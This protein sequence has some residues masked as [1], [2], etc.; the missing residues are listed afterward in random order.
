MIVLRRYMNNNLRNFNYLIGCEESRQAIAVDPLGADEMLALAEEQ[1]YEIKLI[2]NTHEHHDHIDG[3]PRVQEVTGADIWAHKNAAERIPNVARGLVAGDVVELGTIR[4]TV[5]YTP[6]HTMAHLCLLSEDG[7][8]DGQPVLFSGDTLFNACAGN[9]RNGG[10][11]D[12]LYDTFVA[13]FQPLPD[14]TLMHPGHDYMKNNL[15]FALTREPGNDMIQ[16]WL[17]QVSAF[18]AD[19]M[20]VMTLGQERTYNPFL[21]LHQPLIRERLKDAFPALGDGDRDVFKALRTL[22][23]QW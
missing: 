9:C 17:D 8:P 14:D 3:N 2:L 1:G 7:G 4:L 19:E 18:D 20:P 15:S 23:D 22:R 6:G 11:P 13:Q 16:Y 5:L 10:D 12:T 21:R